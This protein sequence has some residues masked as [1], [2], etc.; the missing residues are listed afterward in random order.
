VCP[1]N[2]N[3]ISSCPSIA[4]RS[5]VAVSTPPPSSSVVVGPASV[6]IDRRLNLAIQVDQ[7]NNRVLLVPLPQ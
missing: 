4:V 3:G 5:I 2:P 7:I 1:P 6:A